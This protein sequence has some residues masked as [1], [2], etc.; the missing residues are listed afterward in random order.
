MKKVFICFLMLLAFVT[1]QFADVT[2]YMPADSVFAFTS[3]NNPDNYAKLKE[4]TVFGFLLRDM[5]LEGMLSQQVESMKYAD[6]DFKPENVWALLKGDIGLFVRGEIDYDA[7]AQMDEMSNPDQMMAM[8]PMASLGP[9]MEA[10]EDLNFALILKPTANPGDILKTM[11][12]LLQMELQFGANGP[13]ILAEDNGH[14]LITMDQESM[15]LALKAKADNIMSN[16]VFSKLYREENWMVFYN[17]KMDSK[18]MME[19]MK[20]VY[21]MDFDIDLSEKF[22]M[23]YGWTKGYVKNGLVLESFNDYNYMD[24]EFKNMVINM[25]NSQSALIDKLNMPGFV[26]G[27][28]AL[29][30]MDQVWSMFDP[31][32]KKILSE[33]AKMGG[34]EIPAQDMDMIMKL[35]ESWTG[36]MRLSMDVSMTENGEMSVDM[37]ADMS[38]S[39]IAYIEELIKTSGETLKSSNGMKYMKLSGEM[40]DMVETDPYM[41]EFGTGDFEP[42]LVL[43]QDKLI[44]TTLKPENINAKLAQATPIKS[45]QLFD[46]MN[47]EFKTVDNYYGMMFIDIGD[48]LT[49]MMGMAYPSAIYAEAGVNNEGDSQSVFVIK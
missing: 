37:Y 30:N 49:K 10:I 13:V 17:G 27:A 24:N 21:G 5:G 26:R 22:E 2:D 25:G 18:K 28:M 34:E 20:K 23:E 14:L 33:A 42:Y 48:L 38:S 32:I 8:D 16:S 19:A 29:R 36:D 41:E 7:L 35:M 31:V 47:K 6:P 12:K 15:D 4:Q 45:I 39:D 9:L 11:G 3:I 40:E 1:V 46:S 44:I 43:N